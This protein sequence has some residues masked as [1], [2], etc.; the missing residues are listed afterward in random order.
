MPVNPV[1]QLATEDEPVKTRIVVV[2]LYGTIAHEG[3][4]DMDDSGEEL[5]RTLMQLP[6]GQYEVEIK[7]FR[8]VE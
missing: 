5:L 7:R 4:Y 8:E 1:N 3:W 2:G 6:S